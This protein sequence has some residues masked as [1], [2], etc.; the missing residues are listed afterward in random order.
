MAGL[1]RLLQRFIG[2]AMTLGLSPRQLLLLQDDYLGTLDRL[3]DLR[4][5]A[6]S[7]A[8]RGPLQEFPARG[9]TF[10]DGPIVQV[11]PLKTML[12]K[13]Q[14]LAA[15]FAGFAAHLGEVTEQSQRVAML[16]ISLK[17]L[18]LEPDNRRV[19]ERAC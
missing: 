15:T 18:M 16:V 6:R 4:L 17:R 11:V 14:F 2:E 1:F 5:V 12:D 7:A 19:L 3:I 8:A 9:A 13:A 10:S